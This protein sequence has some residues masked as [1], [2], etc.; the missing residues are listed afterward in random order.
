M[1]KGLS[2]L[3]VAVGV[4][5]ACLAGFFLAVSVMYSSRV[6]KLHLSDMPQTRLERLVKTGYVDGL[7]A[8]FDRV[9]ATT[10][11]SMA[12]TDNRMVNMRTPRARSLVSL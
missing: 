9:V 12:T 8:D 3:A 2:F 6:A 5:T 10:N 7:R 11:A 1:R 4:L